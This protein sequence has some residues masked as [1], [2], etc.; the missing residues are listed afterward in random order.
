MDTHFSIDRRGVSI[1]AIVGIAYALLGA[2]WFLALGAAALVFALSLA[3]ARG[4]GRPRQPRVPPP[5][6]GSPEAAW[7]DRAL[8]AALSIPRL[9]RSA[10]SEAV[11]ARCDAIAARADLSIG[12]LRRLSYQA[13]VVSEMANTTKNARLEATRTQLYGR[14]E[15]YAT[16]LEGVVA[17]LAEV[18]ALGEDAGASIDD[19]TTEIDAL[20]AGLI[21][22]E[23]MSESISAIS[24]RSEANEKEGG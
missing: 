23:T 21:Q 13:S 22:A 24:A 12:S 16:G 2:P 7:L 19:L 10:R 14:I 15:S 18:V 6:P 1:A 4:S 3:F 5:L 8:A 9:R 11:A 20:R 17:R